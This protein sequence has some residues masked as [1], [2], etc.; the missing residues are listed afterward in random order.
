MLYKIYLY[1]NA[2]HK[3]INKKIHDPLQLSVGYNFVHIAYMFC[4]FSADLYAQLAL[5]SKFSALEL[6]RKFI[7]GP[8]LVG[9]VQWVSAIPSKNDTVKSSTV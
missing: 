8:L 9:Y 2:H 1:H 4:M 6:S 7:K 3:L 5:I